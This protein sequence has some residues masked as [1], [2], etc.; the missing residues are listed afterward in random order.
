MIFEF[1]RSDKFSLFLDLSKKLCRR[2]RTNS[3]L[4][5]APLL[6][7]CVAKNHFDSLLIVY[8]VGN[9]SEMYQNA[10]I[11]KNIQL[12]RKILFNHLMID[13]CR[14]LKVRCATVIDKFWTI[15]AFIVSQLIIIFT[16]KCLNYFLFWLYIFSVTN[17]SCP[18]CEKLRNTPLVN[19]FEKS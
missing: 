1:L 16:S 14:Y 6:L 7:A 19:I 5:D 2:R 8:W 12:F 9:V 18:A 4:Y 13:A 10:K 11:L 15:T 17:W 3:S